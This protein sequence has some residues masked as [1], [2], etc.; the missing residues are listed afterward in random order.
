M[1]KIIA[2]LAAAVTL[3]LCLCAC[4]G[5]SSAVNAVSNG[6]GST[7]TGSNITLNTNTNSGSAAN[8]NSNSNATKDQ[9]AIVGNWRS[10]AFADLDTDDHMTRDTSCT[11]TAKSDKTMELSVDGETYKFKW[12]FDTTMDDE[13]INYDFE[14]T[15]GQLSNVLCFGWI[16]SAG[17]LTI[18]ID[19]LAIVLNRA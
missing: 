10:Y 5:G 11:V 8:T 7:N 16:D 4:G 13:D 9:S 3:S 2:L 14:S 15:D 19:S 12:S 1:K 18:C 17:E 6:S